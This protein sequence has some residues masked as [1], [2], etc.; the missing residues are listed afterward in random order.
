M[1]PILFSP[2]SI[3]ARNKY[4]GYTQTSDVSVE[5]LFVDRKNHR[6]SLAIPYRDTLKLSVSYV[7]ADRD[8]ITFGDYVQSHTLFKSVVAVICN[9]TCHGLIKPPPPLLF[10]WHNM[11]VTQCVFLRKRRAKLDNVTVWC[12]IME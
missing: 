8:P 1:R 7:G 5:S 9:D 11:R 3:L 12:A 6:F 10:V 4:T 2:T